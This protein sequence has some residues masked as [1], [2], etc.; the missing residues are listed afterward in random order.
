[1]KSFKAIVSVVRWL[2]PY[3][4]VAATIKNYAT[5]AI[6]T[7]LFLKSVA[8][9]EMGL[10][11]PVV[12]WAIGIA[13]QL[14]RLIIVFGGQ[15]TPFDEIQQSGKHILMAVL[16]GAFALF[17]MYELVYHESATWFTSIAFMLIL[18]IVIEIELV[19]SFT[20]ATNIEIISNEKKKNR[21]KNTMVNLQKFEKFRETLRDLK[22]DDGTDKLAKSELE[23]ELANLMNGAA[24]VKN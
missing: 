16:M 23:R 14:I 18:G 7:A 5:C 1:M 6:L 24:T 4:F 8:P 20:K 19:R 10:L 2:M 21:I 12:P 11:G 17:E 13:S 9:I 22:E 15:L 3:L